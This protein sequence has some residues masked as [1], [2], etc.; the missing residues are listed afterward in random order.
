M[1][2]WISFSYLSRGFCSCGNLALDSS[3]LDSENA[4]S[5]VKDNYSPGVHKPTWFH[6]FSFSSKLSVIETGF[7]WSAWAI[8]SQLTSKG[9][10]CQPSSLSDWSVCWRR[11]L[12]R[13]SCWV[14]RRPSSPNS[15]Q[16]YWRWLAGQLRSDQSFS[17]SWRTAAAAGSS[18]PTLDCSSLTMDCPE[19]SQNRFSG[20]LVCWHSFCLRTC[21]FLPLTWTDAPECPPGRSL[22]PVML[23]AGS[24][25]HLLRSWTSY[26]LGRANTMIRG[27]FY[28]ARATTIARHCSVFVMLAGSPYS[29]AWTSCRHSHK[30][31]DEWLVLCF[32]ST[33]RQAF[34]AIASYLATLA[35][36]SFEESLTSSDLD[37]SRVWKI[38]DH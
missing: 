10:S 25:T 12:S 9:R 4:W 21:Q 32:W 29:P 6:H 35:F 8:G 2:P 31:L 7:R 33:L 13:R 19:A 38:P 5:A 17:L 30:L 11:A 28:F 3:I 36:C 20:P 22:P 26:W 18:V 24:S 27:S 1:R 16:E 34:I 15:S 14:R 23:A 37:C